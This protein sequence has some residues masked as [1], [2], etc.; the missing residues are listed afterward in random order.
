MHTRFLFIALIFISTI[1]QAQKFSPGEYH[2]TGVHEMASGFNFSKDGKYEFYYVYGAMD[3]VSAG[4]YTVVGDT[5]KLKSNK[6]PGHDFNIT[7]Q[8]KEGS[9]YT[10][11]VLDPNTILSN[12]VHCL[13]YMNG[14]KFEEYTDNSGVIRI[15]QDNCE[16]IYI[17]HG[18]YLD[19]P[20]LIKDELN[21]NNYFEV[22]LKPS[23]Q[24]VSFQGIDF[25]I[26]ED[27]IT[28]LPNYFMPM[29]NIRYER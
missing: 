2:L 20:T 7:K 21:S 15:E 11:R 5:I 24:E 9:G 25:F 29:E 1:M 4:T 26:E 16:K 8:K 22:T 23:L 14:V 17:R 10:I 12:N 18:L 27:A 28:C 13:Y 6:I 3:R 19:I